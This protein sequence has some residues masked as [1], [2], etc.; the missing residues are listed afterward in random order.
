MA[1]IGTIVTIITI[2]TVYSGKFS[3]GK[4]FVDET[5]RINFSQM[6]AYSAK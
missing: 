1:I 3:Q 2:I 5:S 6:L 4:I